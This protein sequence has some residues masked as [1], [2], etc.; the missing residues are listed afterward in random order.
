MLAAWRAEKGRARHPHYE[1]QRCRQLSLTGRSGR[2]PGLAS[3][4][5][6]AS[7]NHSVHRL[8]KSSS[9]PTLRGVN[10][11]AIWARSGQA[12]GDGACSVLA[13]FQG[14]G[15]LASHSQAKAGDHESGLEP[16]VPSCLLGVAI[17]Q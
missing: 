11:Q 1:I 14:E 10:G 15:F 16:L 5:S 8:M 3:F 6:D 2:E 7:A 4:P 12:V 13:W 17:P 9:S